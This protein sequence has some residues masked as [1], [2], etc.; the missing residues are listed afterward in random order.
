MDLKGR[1]ALITG[2]S[3][4]LGAALAEELARAGARVA[5]PAAHSR[6]LAHQR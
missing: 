3:K 1:G 5:N 4:G 2:G 6:S